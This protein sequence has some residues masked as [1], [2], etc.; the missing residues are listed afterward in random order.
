MLAKHAPGMRDVIPFGEA[1]FDAI[2]SFGVIV[3]VLLSVLS[4]ARAFLEREECHVNADR[5]WS[6]TR[7]RST[8]VP[9]MRSSPP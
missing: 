3:A 2:G 7:R 8:C 9:P 1:P 4:L 5:R 6:R